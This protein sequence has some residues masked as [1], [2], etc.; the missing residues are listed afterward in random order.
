MIPLCCRNPTRVLFSLVLYKAVDIKSG[1]CVPSK[2]VLCTLLIIIGKGF[3]FFFLPA[4]AYK[5][6]N[7]CYSH[8]IYILYANAGRKKNAKLLSIELIG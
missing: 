6:A 3:V 5:L 2:Y 8:F 4:F 1:F 7:T